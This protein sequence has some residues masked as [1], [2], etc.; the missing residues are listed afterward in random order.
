MWPLYSNLTIYDRT[1]TNPFVS[2]GMI[3]ETLVTEIH[4]HQTCRSQTCLKGVCSLRLSVY[5]V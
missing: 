1:A 4:L 5:P 3:L 2:L